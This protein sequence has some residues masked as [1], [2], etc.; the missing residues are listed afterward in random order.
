[1]VLSTREKILLS[2]MVVLVL[3]T[4]GYYGVLAMRKSE[5]G[6]ED[7]IRVREKLLSRTVVLEQQIQ[8][9][10][11]LTPR[12]NGQQRPLISYVEQLSNKSRLKGRLQLNLIPQSSSNG[13]QAIDIKVD[14]LSLDEM[15]EL[16]YTLENADR[17][18]IIDRFELGPSFR[19]KKRLRLSM[20][21]LSKG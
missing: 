3:V 15:M 14:N 17:S 19:A 8:A 16:V 11:G 10:S 18:L 21:V 7:L 20:R 12:H 1:M 6:M 4:T 9:Q 2:I 5:R 13:L